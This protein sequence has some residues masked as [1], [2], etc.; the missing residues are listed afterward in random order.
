[1][2][3]HS[4]NQSLP[5][6]HVC[7]TRDVVLLENF[8]SLK[9]V[10]SDCRPWISRGKLGI[11]RS[12]GFVQKITDAAFLKDC[13][14]IYR[15]YAVYYQAEGKEQKVFEQSRGLSLTRS[16]SILLQLLKQNALP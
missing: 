8:A 16:E 11:C 4:V 12:C 15:T 5:S 1:M 9:Q 6:C 7:Q 13:E 2:S 3:P 14:E 10:T